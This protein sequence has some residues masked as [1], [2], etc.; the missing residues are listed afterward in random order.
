M[1]PGPPQ[2]ENLLPLCGQLATTYS[3]VTEV[4]KWANSNCSRPHS[5]TMASETVLDIDWPSS[6]TLHRAVPT[7]RHLHNE[8]ARHKSRVSR[9]GVKPGT[10]STRGTHCYYATQGIKE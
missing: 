5:A 1:R 10:Y 6:T 9:T 7:K 2:E 8:N 3:N 4:T